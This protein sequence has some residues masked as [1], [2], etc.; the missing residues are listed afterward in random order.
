VYE[1]HLKAVIA[2]LHAGIHEI[3]I[4]RDADDRDVLRITITAPA[5]E[6]PA[7]ETRL[8]AAAP[9][10]TPRGYRCAFV[11]TAEGETVRPVSAPT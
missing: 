9:S 8:I 4:G 11:F 5:A 1:H 6:I 7:I 3:G 10:I 2:R